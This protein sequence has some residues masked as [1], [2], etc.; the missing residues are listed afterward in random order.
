MTYFIPRALSLCALLFLLAAAP[1]GYYA[2]WG[3]AAALTGSAVIYAVL[4]RRTVKSIR[5]S[6][7]AKRR[8][9][10]ALDAAQGHVS[11]RPGSWRV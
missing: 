7:R 3:W 8:L 9:A 6:R 5:R 2:D 1:V 10:R 11:V 4:A